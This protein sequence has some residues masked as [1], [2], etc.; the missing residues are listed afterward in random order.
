MVD[1]R[2]A[3]SLRQV[4]RQRTTNRFATDSDVAQSLA[5]S[6]EELVD[7]VDD[8]SLSPASAAGS[9]A[10][11][12]HGA[13]SAPSSS[14]AGLSDTQRTSIVG[15]KAKLL[16]SKSHVYL[17]PSP[18]A[19]DNVCGFLGLVEGVRSCYEPLV[20]AWVLITSAS[21]ERSRCCSGYRMSCCCDCTRRRRTRG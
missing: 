10:G 17:H 20:S 19:R 5:S 1:L 18:F 6:D 9:T 4:S 13:Q 21:L 16:F 12:A 8:L 14:H 2:T 15:N 3:A 11:L 7:L